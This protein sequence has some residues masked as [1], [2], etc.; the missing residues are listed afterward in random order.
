MLVDFS[1]RLLS[2]ELSTIIRQ[3]L[4]VV[5]VRMRGKAW[6]S[7]CCF[8]K[9]WVLVSHGTTTAVTTYYGRH[10]RI[11][12]PSGAKTSIEENPASFNHQTVALRRVS[13]CV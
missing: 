13:R 6:C 11:S 5:R 1:Y 7:H 4:R 3:A 9:S 2:R 8:L 10:D 12:H